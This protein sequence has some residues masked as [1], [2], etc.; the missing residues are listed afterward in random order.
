MATIESTFRSY[1]ECI[2]E[3]RW[4][5]LPKFVSFPLDF[6]G[7]EI[8][9]PEAFADKVAAAGY[10]QHEIDAV[11]VDE[12]AQR[13]GATLVA[14]LLPAEAATNKT[15]NLTA[16]KQSMVWA[17]NGKIYKVATIVDDDDV[18][19]QLS[20]PGYVSAPDLIA[21]YSPG[22]TGKKTLSTRELEDIYR[23]YISCINAQ[24]TATDLPRFCHPNVV[25]NT[26]RLPLDQYRLL[27]QDAF[28]AIPDIVFGIDTVVAD[29]RAQRVAVRLQFTGTPTGTFAGAEPTGRS[30]RFGEFVT[31]S[32]R[33]GK[34]DR[35][36]SIVDWKT[37]RQQLQQD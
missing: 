8:H 20:E 21:T 11:T 19:R 10:L 16:R 35:V 30:V 27:M 33:D 36:W 14:K 6:N 3:E 28:T 23:A 4:Q 24:T 25:H 37:Y 2:N 34:I 32:F 5:D 22:A 15:S 12:D 29:E 31:Y 1:I 17:K 13:L 7:E 9:A 18:Q 26:R